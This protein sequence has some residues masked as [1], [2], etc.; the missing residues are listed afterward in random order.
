MR[1]LDEGLEQNI[2]LVLA[3][4]VIGLDELGAHEG[5]RARR[6]PVRHPQPGAP[7][8]AR[9]LSILTAMANVLPDLDARTGPCALYQGLVHVAR[10]TGNQPPNFDLAPLDT[11]ETRPERYLDWFRRLRRDAGWQEAAERT[12]RTA[13]HIGLPRAVVAT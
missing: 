1:K 10:S 4:S 5:R 6:R 2:R 3:K 11:S 9:G 13:I 12:L 7:A 8:G